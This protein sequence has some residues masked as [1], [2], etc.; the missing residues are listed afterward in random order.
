MMAHAGALAAESCFNGPARVDSANRA[1]FGVPKGQSIRLEFA[2]NALWENVIFVC[3]AITGETLLE[4]GNG[5]RSQ[6][7]WN[8]PIDNT[9]SLAYYI[10]AF[11][12]KVRQ[13]YA[14][15][16]RKPW[17]QSPMVVKGERSDAPGATGSF[18]QTFG[19]TDGG[20]AGQGSNAMVT[21]YFGGAIDGRP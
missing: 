20:A 10:V 13:N 9:R 3:D 2:F 6:E 11:H 16:H 7:D 17:F 15:A 19:F 5:T 12:K 8:T 4:R 18:V 1:Q 21:A 14:G